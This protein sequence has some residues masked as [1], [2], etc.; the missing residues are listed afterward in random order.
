MCQFNAGVCHRDHHPRPA[1]IR[2]RGSNIQIHSGGSAGT[3]TVFE[4]P[5]LDTKIDIVRLRRVRAVRSG[6]FDHRISGQHFR[7]LG[8]PMGFTQSGDGASRLQDKYV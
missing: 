7:Q 5:L 3:V 6:F 2:P 8:Q 1:G 4:I